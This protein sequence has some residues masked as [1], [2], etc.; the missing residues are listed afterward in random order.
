M[1]IIDY[2]ALPLCQICHQVR[3]IKQAARDRD[4]CYQCSR[5]KKARVYC[6]HCSWNGR[7]FLLG[8]CPT[9]KA[10]GRLHLINCGVLGHFRG[11]ACQ[12]A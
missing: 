1:A 12:D 6:D 2:A 7:A 4:A 11:C 3:L 8:P 5:R 9:C 10:F